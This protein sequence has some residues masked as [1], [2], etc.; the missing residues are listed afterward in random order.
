MAGRG[1]L[2]ISG[3]FSFLKLDQLSNIQSVASDRIAV[4]HG[5]GAL[6]GWE[7]G[8]AAVFLAA[9]RTA[10]CSNSQATYLDDAWRAFPDP[11]PCTRFVNRSC[12][13]SRDKSFS[14]RLKNDVLLFKNRHG[15]GWVRGKRGGGCK[16]MQRKS[17]NQELLMLLKLF[18]FKQ[19]LSR[20]H[21]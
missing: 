9:Q 7:S 12:T 17:K 21:I 4:G 8:E 14:R 11:A 18:F 2:T 16:W 6:V 15:F 20:L 10:G 5:L 3:L 13:L 19:K 1:A